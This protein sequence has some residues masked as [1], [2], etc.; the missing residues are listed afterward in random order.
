MKHLINKVINYFSFSKNRYY[1]YSRDVYDERYMI[2]FHD[3]DD[4]R[5]YKWGKKI[6][7]WKFGKLD[8]SLVKDIQNN[9]KYLDDDDFYLSTP[10]QMCMIQLYLLLLVSHQHIRPI[11]NPYILKPCPKCSEM[12]SS[13]KWEK[14]LEL[15]IKY[16]GN[17]LI[18]LNN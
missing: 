10:P 4:E 7:E 2:D 14:E 1:Y 6:Y 12:V 9:C 15:E 5:D 13:G 16:E 18:I 11:D 3:D 17:D 8:G